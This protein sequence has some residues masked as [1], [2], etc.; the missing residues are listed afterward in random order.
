MGCSYWAR[1]LYCLNA[2]SVTNFAF[3]HKKVLFVPPLFLFSTY[4]NPCFWYIVVV[5]A[6]VRL[7][8]GTYTQTHVHAYIHTFI[9]TIMHILQAQIEAHYAF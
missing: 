4:P 1:I 6:Q 3:P 9:K 7:K 5:L 8:Y 2:C